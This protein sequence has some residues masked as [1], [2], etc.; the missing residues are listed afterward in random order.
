MKKPIVPWKRIETRLYE[1]SPY[2]KIEDVLFELPDGRQEWYALK[3]EGTVVGVLALTADQRVILAR[4]FRPGP[5]QVVDELPGGGVARNEAALE[6]AKREL[7][8]E[9]GFVPKEIV[10]LGTILDCAY[11]TIIREGFVATGCERQHQQELDA[12]EYI[13]VVLKPIPEFIQQLMQGACTDPEIGWMGLYHLGF[14]TRN[15][16]VAKQFS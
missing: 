9:T 13:D 2:R 10:S 15:P 6:A 3:K 1:H 4:Q 14:L 7:Q 12:N 11:S 8:E 16:Q 5:N